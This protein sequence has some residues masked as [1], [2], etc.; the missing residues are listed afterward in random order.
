[1]YSIRN[2]IDRLSN[3]GDAP[4]LGLVPLDF[5]GITTLEHF[6]KFAKS[7]RA[8]I[9]PGRS[10]NSSAIQPWLQGPCS[11]PNGN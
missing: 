11:F 8:L 5:P 9:F 1:M 3:D 4:R 10:N 7:A 6:Y 2:S